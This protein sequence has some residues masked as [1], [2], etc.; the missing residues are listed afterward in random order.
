MGEASR[1]D[2]SHHS[3]VAYA[4]NDKAKEASAREVR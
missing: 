4:G 1:A 2:S 3:Q